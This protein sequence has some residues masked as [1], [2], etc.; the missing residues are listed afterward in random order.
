MTILNIVYFTIVR[1]LRDRRTLMQMM[2]LPVLMILILGT[3]LNSQFTPATIG[4]SSVAFL[5]SD[6]KWASV[7]F[8]EF[9]HLEEIQELLEVQTVNSYDEG[10]ELIE[11]GDITALLHIPEG[12]TTNLQQGKDA[13]IEVVSGIQRGFRITIIENIVESYVNRG[14]VVQAGAMV[15]IKGLAY[16]S[17]NSLKENTISTEGNIPS[18]MD[19]Y[20][21]TMLVM[22]LMYGANYGLFGIAED[23]FGTVGAR[24]KSTPISGY[25]MY[26]GKTLGTV[27]TLFCQALIIVFFTKYVY[28]V[29]WGDN[30]M[31]IF[32]ICLTLSFFTTGFGIMLC[33][34]SPTR[35]FATNIIN[36]VVPVFT[37][38]AGGY[39]P[40]PNLGKVIGKARYLS[41]NYIGQRA[42][43]SYIY[44]GATSNT[45]YF[46]LF[47]WGLSLL[48]MITAISV[49]R[50]QAA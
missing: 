31:A 37:F 2:A 20:G 27:L 41:P 24:I 9:L 18:S 40:L 11:E 46:V 34:L 35:K 48:T 12:Y 3:A 8:E 19:Y 45:M 7:S 50:R 16:D 42:F 36:L 21:I 1:N 22:I 28:G 39:A 38:L 33:M 49:G 15:G 10:I 6:G 32:G 17:Q 4:T 5:N 43:F 29:N 44:E 26:I 47:L 14:N 30:L 23:F 13:N 25:E